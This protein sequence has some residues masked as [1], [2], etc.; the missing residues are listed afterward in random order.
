MRKK[1]RQGGKKGWGGGNEGKREEVW[2]K[3]EEGNSLFIFTVSIPVFFFFSN[4]IQFSPFVSF[5]SYQHKNDLFYI[6]GLN[7]LLF[8]IF[9][10]TLAFFTPPPPLLLSF[11]FFSVIPCMQNGDPVRIS[12]QP[13][14]YFFT[15]AAQFVQWRCQT[16]SPIQFA[17][18]RVLTTCTS[19]WFRQVENLNFTETKV[20]LLKM[21]FPI[22]INERRI[23]IHARLRYETDELLFLIYLLAH[24]N[25]ISF[26][27]FTL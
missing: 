21:I 7:E 2:K 27:I 16:W 4:S 25:F 13:S 6:I 8:F 17:D 5:C 22:I 26:L 11:F 20:S 1:A 19:S 14:F 18:S 15:D 3:L 10:H 24:Y 12:I 9:F 23:K